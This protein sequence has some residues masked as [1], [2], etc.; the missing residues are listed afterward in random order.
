MPELKA[1]IFDVDGTLADTE[2]DGH[3]IAFNLAFADAGLDWDWTVEIYEDLLTVTGGKERMQYFLDKYK[4]QFNQPENL[5]SYIADMHKAK[6]AHYTDLLSRGAI[7]LRPGVERLLNEAREKGLRLAIATTT[8]PENVSA[9]LEHTLG[10][11]SM[12]WFEVIAAGDIVP[13]KK[14]AADIYNFA[15]EK[16]AL[17]ADECIAFEDSRNGILSSLGANLKT[18]ITINDYT[19]DHD[20]TG[21]TIVLDQYGEPDSPFSVIAGDAQGFNYLNI[22]MVKA[23]HAG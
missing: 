20:F 16:M 4:P 3:R 10:K 2:R 6:T 22:E 15:L 7:P 19:K 17:T 8:T 13:A 1:L 5:K 11:E 9:L 12:D 18:I 21:A 23:L 14:P